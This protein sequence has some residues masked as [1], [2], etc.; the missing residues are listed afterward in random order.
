MDE[1]IAIQV[2]Q[3]WL[4]ELPLEQ[5]NGLIVRL[6]QLGQPNAALEILCAAYQCDSKDAKQHF[7][8]ILETGIQKI[9][10]G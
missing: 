4:V 3:A 1:L 8:R 7:K 10:C 6:A 9:Q 5:F 2:P